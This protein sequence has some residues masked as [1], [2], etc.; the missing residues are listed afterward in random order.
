MPSI[1]D[2]DLLREVGCNPYDIFYVFFP[3]INEQEREQLAMT[4]S[5]KPLF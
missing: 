4:L 5:I 2:I 1:Q 3:E